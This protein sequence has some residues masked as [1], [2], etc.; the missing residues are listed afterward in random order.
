[1]PKVTLRTAGNF[2]GLR[3]DGGGNLLKMLK[4]QLSPFVAG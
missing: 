3:A 2:K 4:L 1:M